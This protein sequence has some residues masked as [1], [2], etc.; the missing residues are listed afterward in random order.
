MHPTD[1]AARVVGAWYLSMVLTGPFTLI[2]I[3]ST[4]I[5]RGDAVATASRIL[6]HQTMFRLGIAAE[7][8]GAVIFLCTALA[9]YRLFRDVSQTRAVQLLAFAAVSAGVA[10]F[11]TL[12]N[13]AAFA[14]FRGGEFLGAL[15]TPQ[16]EALGML[17]IR[18]HGQG[19]VIN[20]IFWGLWL[21]P[22]GLLVIQSRFM[23]RFIGVWLLVNGAAYVALCFI[24]LFAPQYSSI[25]FTSAQPALFA[26]LAF[27]LW[28]LIKGA[29]VPPL[30]AVATA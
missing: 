1:K 7:V 21:V 22:M 2:Y 23:P 28:L 25:A 11:N 9:L 10:F 24:G 15:P 30:P 20:E 29:K 12:N 27:M 17:F 16:R 26:E 13:V 18:L 3:P 5:V 19:N 8:V 14:L 6:E 4:L